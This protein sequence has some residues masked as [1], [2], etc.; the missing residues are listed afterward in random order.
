VISFA[1]VASSARHPEPG[2]AEVDV[3]AGDAGGDVGTPADEWWARPL[4]ERR[5]ARGRQNSTKCLPGTAAELASKQGAGVTLE[6][7]GMEP[8]LAGDAG[9]H[10]GADL[11]TIVEGKD[12]VGSSLPR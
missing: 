9:E 10:S 3:K 8:G 7:V 1:N 2:G 12:E 6:V 5:L 11:I 4:G